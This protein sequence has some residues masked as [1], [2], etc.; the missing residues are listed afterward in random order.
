M[1]RSD[2]SRYDFYQGTGSSSRRPLTLRG[3]GVPARER[4]T[5][6]KLIPRDT[7][8]VIEFPDREIETRGFFIFKLV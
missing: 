8:P 2:D 5:D 3:V 6:W 1:A 4:M 7:P